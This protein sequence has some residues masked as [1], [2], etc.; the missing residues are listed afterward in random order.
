MK[1]QFALLIL[2]CSILFWTESTAQTFEGLTDLKDHSQEVYYSPGH[3]TR[4]KEI[5]ARCDRAVAYYNKMLGFKPSTKLFIL[6]PDEW[7]KYATVPIYGMPHYS[8]SATLVIA[9]EDNPFWK[10][11]L[12]PLDVLPAALAENVKKVYTTKEENLSAMAFFDLLALHELGHGFHVQG[13]L[14][15]QRLWMQELFVN[16]MLHTY[17]AENEPDLLPAL[18]TFPQMVIGAGSSEY[19]HTSLADFEKLYSNMNPKNYGWYQC[20]LHYAAKLIY[21]A[22]GKDVLLKLWTVLKTNK[23]KLTDEQFAKVLKSNVHPSV[24]DVLTKW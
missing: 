5:A 11:F 12:P 14:K 9:S 17:I 4:A 21:E 8:D 22:G 15:M 19:E 16:I 24:A 13:G 3:E 20:R 7:K 23:E 10:S 6:G 2:C 1:K 18:E